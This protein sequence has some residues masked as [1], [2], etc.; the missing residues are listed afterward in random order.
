MP[1]RR[2]LTR[3]ACRFALCCAAFAVALLAISPVSLAQSATYLVYTPEGKRTLPFRVI[4]N[5]DMATLDQVASL[6]GLT[7][8]QD[9]LVGGFTVRG[10]GQTILLIPGQSFASIGPGKIVS[11]PAP[12]QRDR[13]IWIVPVEFLSKAVGPAQNMRIDVRKATHTILAGD[14]RLPQVSARFERQ[15]PNGRLTF[16]IQ[17]ATPHRMARNGNRLTLRFEAVALEWNPPAAMAAEFVSGIRVDGT[18]VLIDLGPAT[19]GYRADDTD[20]THL[21]I[22]F[23]APAPVAP[24]PPPQQ[25]A[26][27]PAAPLAP[28][29]PMPGRG[30]SLELPPPPR[31]AI[32]TTSGLRTVVIDPGHG[33]D[34]AGAKGARGTT[35]KD[36]VLQFARKLKTAIESRIGLRVLLTRDADENI[37][38]DR[39]AALANNN[40][41]DLFISL[42]ANASVRPAVNG[43]Q[44]LSLK[45]DD[46]AAQM[47]PAAAADVPVS[48]L[49]GGTRAIDVLPWDTAQVGFT[50]DSSSI[51]TI[52]RQHLA[53][54]KIP[55]FNPTASHMP[56][57]PLVGVSMPAVLVE[58]GFLTNTADEQALIASDR[59]QQV[60]DAI[61]ATIGD[62]RRGVPADAAPRPDR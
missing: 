15:G 59:P 44:V 13:N 26:A 49:G 43:M 22:D 9:A 35:E 55:L 20:T 19:A 3:V 32:D 42:H 50:D 30:Q 41:A 25:P 36:Y 52:L 62:I 51:A 14:V 29:P 34:D 37:A 21:Q 18:S 23:L 2:F 7:V 57:R 56:L 6:F 38:P 16:E 48:V 40:K 61:L 10:K 46:Y 12:V 33:G 11:L 31:P 54:A 5:V 28:Q 27:V 39:R 58:L 53:E 17:P 4:N 8:A 24:P 45:L 60:I 47:D 1:G